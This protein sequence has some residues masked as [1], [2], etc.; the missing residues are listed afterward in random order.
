MNIARELRSNILQPCAS[1]GPVAGAC[2]AAGLPSVRCAVAAGQLRVAEV[3]LGPDEI[4]LVPSGAALEAATRALAVGGGEIGDV[5]ATVD[6]KARL[7]KRGWPKA[8][9]EPEDFAARGK[10]TTLRIIIRKR[11]KQLSHLLQIST[12]RG[13]AQSILH[14]P[15]PAH[16]PRRAIDRRQSADLASGSQRHQHGNELAR[17]ILKHIVPRAG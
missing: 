17:A 6:A 3:A 14:P 1:E 13:L 12:T 15:Y 11:V 8:A 10:F 16:A 2:E 4:R 5:V 9:F 7:L